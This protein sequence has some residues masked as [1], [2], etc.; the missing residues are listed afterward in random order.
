M[1]HSSRQICSLGAEILAGL[2]VEMHACALG[3]IYDSTLAI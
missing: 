2:T 3:V 1:I